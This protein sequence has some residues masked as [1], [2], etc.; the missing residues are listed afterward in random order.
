MGKVDK[1]VHSDISVSGFVFTVSGMLDG[2]M[3]CEANKREHRP[4]SLAR[5]RV[6]FRSLPRDVPCR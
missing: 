1:I 2:A 3:V 4:L 5:I 6:H